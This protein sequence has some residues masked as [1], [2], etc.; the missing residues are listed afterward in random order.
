VEIATQHGVLEVVPADANHD[1]QASLAQDGDFGAL[2]R[3]QY[4]RPL[5]QQQ[6]AGR[7]LQPL[8]DAGDEG[9]EGHQLVRRRLAR[10][11]EGRTGRSEL[12]PM[13]AGD[14][15]DGQHV[16]K[17]A[18]LSRLGPVADRRRVLANGVGKTNAIPHESIL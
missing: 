5:R 18:A 2:L 17:T 3:G 7:Q 4:R 8:G 15:I 10:V 16:V 11:V 6:H 13:H 1:A 12:V 9:K 14:V